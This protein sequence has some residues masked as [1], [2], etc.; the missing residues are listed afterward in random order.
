MAMMVDMRMCSI[1]RRWKQR[2]AGET[3]GGITGNEDG[4]MT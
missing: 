3:G 2:I 1:G 4:T